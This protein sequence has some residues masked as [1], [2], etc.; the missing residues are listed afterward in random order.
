MTI[1]LFLAFSHF[2]IYNIRKDPLQHTRVSI[3]SFFIAAQ[4][5]RL[6]RPPDPSASRSC[7]KLVVKKSGRENES[8]IESDD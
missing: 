6:S 5:S 3:T 8:R 4:N 7:R 1:D 2:E